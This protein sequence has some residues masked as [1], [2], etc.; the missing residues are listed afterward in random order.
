[1][2]APLLSGA[3][4]E[5]LPEEAGIEGLTEALR[6]GSDRSLVKITPAHLELLSHQL[7]PEEA[8]GRVRAF[9][10][11]GEN[12]L[13]EKI[14]F[15]LENSPDTTLVNEYGPTETVVGCCVYTLDGRR[16]LPSTV[17]IGRPIANTQ[18]YILDRALRP[19]PVGIS[20]ELYI[21][22]AGLARG[23][24]NRPEL[25]AQKFIQVSFDSGIPVRLYKTGDLARYM[26]DGNI[27]C[28][29][30]T[31]DQVKI[32]GFRIELGEIEAVL[33]EHPAVRHACVLVRED[34]P[35][36]RRLA[37]YVVLAD[38]IPVPL[39][40]II[41]FAKKKLP[42]HMIPE[43]VK[44]D[45][46]P[47]TPGGKLDRRALPAPNRE[48]A[49]K[50]S[51]F[52]EPQDEIEKLFVQLWKEFLKLDRVS[53]FDNF[54]DLGGHSL[55]AIQVVARVH[56]QLGVRLKPS[57]VAFQSLGQLASLCRERLQRR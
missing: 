8:A 14:R 29:G 26:P 25:T 54:F 24:L 21:G 53:I 17:P 10:I 18:L 16:D 27:E 34:I 9:I 51:T 11:G 23:Y 12:L 7:R 31:D 56:S 55:T 36:D 30:R 19:V 2:F 5:L 40:E 57:E 32:R 15:W 48:R 38:D 22:G 37:A 39:A 4:V 42:T 3:S 43:L 49:F 6:T 33:C 45:E 41:E 46:L 44:V 20:G 50:D 52:A 28:L 1:L 47:L 13:T 35:G